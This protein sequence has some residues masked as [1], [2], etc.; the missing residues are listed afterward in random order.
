MSPALTEVLERLVS[1]SPLLG[2]LLGFLYAIHRQRKRQRQVDIERIKAKLGGTP[3]IDKLDPW[4]RIQVQV[5]ALEQRTHD[6]LQRLATDP[7]L[8]GKDMNRLH[9]KLVRR[10]L[11]GEEDK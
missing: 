6:T 8:Q 2:A 1:A 7:R 5:D 9:R 10:I 4:E 3:D 11:Q